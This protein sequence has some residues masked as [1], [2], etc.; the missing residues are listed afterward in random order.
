MVAV[1]VLTIVIYKTRFGYEV[2][3]IGENPDAAKYAGIDF[4]RTTMLIMAISGGMAGLAG[5]GEVAGIHHYLSYPDSISSGLWFYGDYCG[6]VGQ[7]QS[8]LRASFQASFL[9]ASSWVE[10]RFRYRSDCRRQR[11]LFLT[12]P[13]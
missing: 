5:V 13:C 7:A 8:D 2:R 1:V 9:P 11:W 12:E 3:V 4:S 10:T 6:L